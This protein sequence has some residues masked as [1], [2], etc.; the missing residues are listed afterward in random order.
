MCVPEVGVGE[1]RRT[2][3]GPVE[4][5]MPKVRAFQRGGQPPAA[6]K[7]CVPEIGPDRIRPVEAR[8]AEI[9]AAQV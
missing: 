3:L 7:I 4:S 1:P 6:T 2:E 8:S 5:S 9:D